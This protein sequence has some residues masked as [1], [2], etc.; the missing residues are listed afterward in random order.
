MNM[1]DNFMRNQ[2][3]NMNPN[4]NIMNTNNFKAL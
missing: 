4:M 1:Q 3:V 2:M